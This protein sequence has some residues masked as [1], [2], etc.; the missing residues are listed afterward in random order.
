MDDNVETLRRQDSRQKAL[1]RPG[2]KTS[3]KM[4]E[5]MEDALVGAFVLCSVQNPEGRY[6]RTYCTRSNIVGLPGRKCGSMP[7]LD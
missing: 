7:P 1:G 6:L 5:A 3:R 2:L 4:A